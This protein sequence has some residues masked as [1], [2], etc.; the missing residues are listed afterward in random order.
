MLDTLCSMSALQ[1]LAAEHRR[2]G[3]AVPTARV[4]GKSIKAANLNTV[5]SVKAKKKRPA[6]SAAQ[7]AC[8]PFVNFMNAEQ[9]KAKRSREGKK[10]SWDEN[11]TV[12]KQCQHR[13]K[14]EER[15]RLGWTG[16]HQ[17]AVAE[18]APPSVEP[19]VQVN[20]P[21]FESFWG[22]GDEESPIRKELVQETVLEHGV[23]KRGAT[24]S[25]G[26][27]SVGRTIA[28]SAAGSCFV[29][30]PAPAT[31][32]LTKLHSPKTCHEQHLGLCVKDAGN[33]MPIIKT[34][35]LNFNTLFSSFS[36][37]DLL[38]RVM[39]YINLG[40]LRCF[41]KCVSIS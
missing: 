37:W 28:D 22:V 35:A 25:P 17:K 19:S 2:R 38:G 10:G 9:R 3:G 32:N 15:L 41:I 29:C 26:P 1:N 8:R 24:C 31:K 13:W 20:A 23:I 5:S 18:W 11:S 4:T 7:S 27:I 12:I 14:N 16:K 30:D 33:L 39:Q 21:S 6:A 34:I 36:K 40:I